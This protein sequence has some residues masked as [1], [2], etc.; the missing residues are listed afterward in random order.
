MLKPEIGWR[1]SATAAERTARSLSVAFVF[2][3]LGCGSPSEPEDRR[4]LGIVEGVNP[5]DPHFVV[6]AE[7]EAGKPF[8]VTVR[9]YALSSC[10]H[11]VRTDVQ[12]EEYL[13]TFIPYD[14]ERVGETCTEEVRFIEHSASV[15]F[16]DPG[17]AVVNIFGRDRREPPQRGK[18]YAIG[19]WV[20]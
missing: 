9:T 14:E 15:R 8:T 1:I 20:K 4:E 6:P 18:V 7:V 12:I 11:K 16:N 13:A 17:P 10:V 19:V 3:A 2:F 5:D